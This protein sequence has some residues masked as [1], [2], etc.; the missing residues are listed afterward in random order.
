MRDASVIQPEHDHYGL[1]PLPLRA[2]GRVGFPV[3]PSGLVGR[4]ADLAALLEQLQNPQ[5]RLLT[6][7]GPGGVGKT[8]LAI[9]AAIRSER[10]FAGA[11]FVALAA[12]QD[13][14]LVLSTIAHD[15]GV[16]EPVDGQVYEL[17]TWQEGR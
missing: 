16:K 1:T 15:L 6:L 7:T 13:P 14:A 9:A 4:D 5:S 11:A 12:V 10:A 2:P 3:V 8:R 17:V